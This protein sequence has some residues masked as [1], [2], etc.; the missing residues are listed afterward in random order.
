MTRV[1]VIIPAYNA[2]EVVDTSL[3]SV[4]AQTRPP[5]EVVLVDDGSTDGTAEVLESYRSDSRVRIITSPNNQGLVAALGL[6]LSHCRSELVARLDADDFAR[7]TRLSR[8]A[9]VFEDPSVVLCA[10]AYDR[11]SEDGDLLKHSLPPSSHAELAAAMLVSNRLHHS[12][13][14]FRRAAV[15]KVGG[16]DPHWFPVEDYDLWLRL[17]DTGRYVGLETTESVYVQT[18]TGISAS[19]NV[20]QSQRQGE[21]ASLYRAVLTGRPS[22]H[23]RIGT[24]LE[25][26]RSALSLR[27][28]LRRR[29]IPT[30]GI[31]RQVLRAVNHRLSSDRPVV[32]TAITLSVAP[33]VTI[34]GRLTTD[35][36]LVRRGRQSPSR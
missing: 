5:D 20:V 7:P 28:R 32:R 16:Y 25:F 31:D 10:T 30:A 19:M 14:M 21:R 36:A 29:G 33:R 6:G 17:L 24:T 4:A 23:G 11:I 12:S 22:A 34:L 35:S 15:A 3:G 8:Q 27:R 18:D 2:A 13:V 1:S 26:A 9:T